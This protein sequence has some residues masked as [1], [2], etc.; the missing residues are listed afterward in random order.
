MADA[1]KA[2]S[3]K[4]R[5]QESRPEAACSLTPIGHQRRYMWVLA[6]NARAA[7]GAF[8]ET[9]RDSDDRRPS[10]C[11]RLELLSAVGVL[12]SAGLSQAAAAI[13][14]SQLPRKPALRR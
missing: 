14:I 1:S 12:V 6:E 9:G 7:L 5:P 3:E 11:Y 10:V 13:V 2:E 4:G 8:Y